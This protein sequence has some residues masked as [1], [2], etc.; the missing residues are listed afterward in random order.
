MSSTTKHYGII[1]GV[2]GSS[3]SDAAVSWAAH[4]AVLR[5]LPLTLMHVQD[6]M[7][8]AWSPAEALK[9]VAGWH[10]AEGRGILANASKIAHDISKDASQITINGEMQFA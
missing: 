4:D 3:A 5:G 10:E 6:P 9:E 7:S 8:R 1:V 2:D